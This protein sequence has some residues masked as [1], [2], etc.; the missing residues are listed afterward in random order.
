MFAMVYAD[1][2]PTARLLR[3]HGAD[4]DEVFHQETPLIYAMRHR[5]ARFGEWLLDEGA[6]PSLAD[7]RGLTALHHAVRRRLPDATLRALR[8]RGADPSAVSR[9]GLSAGDLATRAQKRI[10]GVEDAHAG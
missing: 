5:C 10:L 9:D 3:R 8:A 4:L 2:L 7:G 6:N 1:A